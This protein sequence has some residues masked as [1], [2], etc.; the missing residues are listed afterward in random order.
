[1]AQRRRAD[2]PPRVRVAVGSLLGVLALIAGPSAAVAETPPSRLALSTVDQPGSFFDLTMEPGGHRSLE[3]AISNDG[4]TSLAART[5]AAD[6]YTIV[7]GGFGGRL[8]DAPPTGTTSWLDYA[9]ASLLVKAGERSRRSFTVNV[10]AD[11]APGE[12]ITSLIL[13]H[14]RSFQAGGAIDVNQVVR[15]AVAVVV[16]VPGQRSPSLEVGDASHLVVAGKSIVSVAVEN[17]GN[18]RLKPL[19]EFTLSD[20]AGMQVSHASVAMDSFYAKTAT[21]VEVPLTALL[22]PGA[23]VVRLTLEDPGQGLES[24][25]TSIPLL[26][27]EPPVVAPGSGTAP[28]LTDVIQGLRGES[29]AFVWGVLISGLLALAL[30]IVGVAMAVRRRRNAA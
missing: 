19:I 27:E 4:D 16:T 6:V 9:P 28:G 11:A 8:R 13:E 26:V 10:P 25:E 20:A 21:S 30:V 17:S 14:D 18:V 23:Y 22:L 12:Y 5:Y 29:L 24:F 7:N 2:R 15:Q 3:V 1:V